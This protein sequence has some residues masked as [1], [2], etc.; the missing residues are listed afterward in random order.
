MKGTE[1]EAT[2]TVTNRNTSR[3]STVNFTCNTT[4]GF[5][6]LSTGGSLTVTAAD[7]QDDKIN[8]QSAMILYT[9]DGNDI[10]NYTGGNSSTID[11][12]SGDDILNINSAYNGT[13][14]GGDGNDEIN[15]NANSYAN[16]HWRTIYGGNGND[17][18]N[19]NG[20]YNTVYGD[21]GNDEINMNVGT[22]KIYGGAGAD[23]I[24]INAENDSYATDGGAGNDT[25]YVQSS[26]PGGL[27]GGNDDD[28]FIVGKGVVGAFVDG[29][30]G[31]NTL[32][33]Y[34]TDTHTYN[35]QGHGNVL[36]LKGILALGANETVTDLI[37]G[38]KSYNF[39]NRAASSSIIS[40][41][42]NETT[43]QI[44]FEGTDLT[45]T[46]ISATANNIILKGANMYV[47]TSGDYNDTIV[48]NGSGSKV[49]TYGG[50][51]TITMNGTGSY[52]YGGDG[53]DVINMENSSSYAYGGAGNDII[54]MKSSSSYAYG[55]DDNDTIIL[56]G[57]ASYA[58]GNNGDDNI[59]FYGGNTRVYGHAGNDTITMNAVNNASSPVNGG[60]GDDTIYVNSKNN[61]CTISGGN[62]NDTFV[63][64][65]TGNTIDGNTGSNT[66]VQNVNSTTYS[67]I[68]KVKI[69]NTSGIIN[70]TAGSA[71]EVE[72]LNGEIYTL[73]SETAQSISYN[74]NNNLLTLNANNISVTSALGQ[75]DN[76]KVIGNNNIINCVDGNDNIT[77]QGDNNTINTTEGTKL[78][79]V[80]GNNNTINGSSGNDNITTAGDNNTISGNNGDDTIL[81]SS[82]NNNSITGGNGND[83]ITLNGTNAEGFDV[84][85]EAGND[86][87]NI[88]S[89]DNGCTFDAGEGEN[90]ITN[91]G[92][93]NTILSG[94]N[95]DTITNYG[96][97]NSINSGAGNDIIN[98]TGSNN[99]ITTG[100][101][102]DEITTSGNYNTINSG[103]G[104]DTIKNSGNNNNILGGAGD[105][106]FINEGM[107]NTINGNDGYNTMTEKGSDTTL[108]NVQHLNI[109]TAKGVIN[110]NANTVLDCTIQ[111]RTYR[112]T[113]SSAED[114]NLNFTA[115][116]AETKFVVDNL[117]IECLDEEDYKFSV[118]GNN[119]NI[120]GNSG[121]DTIKIIGN[122]NSVVSKE[123]DDSIVIS[124]NGNN[125]QSN[126]GDD[127]VT[128]LEGNGN[129]L[130]GGNGYDTVTNGGTQTRITSF[131]SLN[132]LAPDIDIQVGAYGDE[133]SVLTISTGL[134]L[135]IVEYDLLSADAALSALS[136]LDNIISMITEKRANIGVSYNKL[137]NILNANL[138]RMTNLSSSLSTI[139]DT[140]IASES[141]K[142]VKQKILTQA[143]SSLITQSAKI[144]RDIIYTL[145]NKRA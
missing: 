68:Q 76:L 97:N 134:M 8:L 25:I 42:C 48:A 4:T 12:G 14:K 106:S 83:Y 50:D 125:V 32:T 111:D 19:I 55:G 78:T 87:I 143:T 94:S 74:A 15:V 59:T 121:N 66:I 69:G 140:D 1:F 133:D 141:A 114:M 107:N 5:I 135:P 27:M 56:E 120:S 126:N 70:L 51:D 58:E 98:N 46:S 37:I 31:Y 100:G 63:M 104:N 9:K 41:D 67:N 52:A 108:L 10:V 71:M 101:G 53:N 110:I 103:D 91:S 47:Y 34:G 119:N 142:L 136:D 124:G 89:S 11:M 54:N 65:A 13:F 35:I 16:T 131:N 79:I 109:M 7:G 43:G 44:T 21:A 81:V 99:T 33:D 57:A 49:W 95:N 2:Y 61:R 60:D 30:A 77:V 23:N 112:F 73:L 45:I 82:G 115:N 3:V 20:M 17:T 85:G 130:N 40:F 24:Y 18:I 6:N 123:G 127:S 116:S 88:T 113:N 139:Q 145:I 137:D 105:D 102:K 86:T 80:Q 22:N 138:T 72:N 75:N 26:N 84:L 144:N 93:N 38:G 118:T 90:I 128:I 132:K 129:I 62:G 117:K 28:H 96:N 36:P 39:T 92:N 29:G 122:N 64:N